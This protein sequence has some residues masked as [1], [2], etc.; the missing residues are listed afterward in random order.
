MNKAD[1]LPPAKPLYTDLIPFDCTVMDDTPNPISYLPKLGLE[2]FRPGQKDV[3]DNGSVSDIGNT[4]S[5]AINWRPLLRIPTDF[6]NEGNDDDNDDDDDDDDNGGGGEEEEEEDADDG[7]TGI[8]LSL[9]AIDEG[10][11]FCPC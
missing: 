6:C 10:A 5:V 4:T 1:E 8:V 3:V 9:S 7:A 2:R 11:N